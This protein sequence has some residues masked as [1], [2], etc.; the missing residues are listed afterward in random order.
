MFQLG[1]PKFV[2]LMQMSEVEREEVLAQRL[3]EMQRIQ[4]KRNLDEMLRA[5]KDRANDF[6]GVTKTAKRSHCL[7]HL[8]GYQLLC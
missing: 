3:E 7:T 4:D 8:C 5:Q 1:L 6:D 2:R